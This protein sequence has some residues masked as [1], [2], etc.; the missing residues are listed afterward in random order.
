MDPPTSKTIQYPHGLITLI[1]LHQK[2]S[3]PH[4]FRPD[5]YN[6]KAAIF[7]CTWFI[8]L[9]SFGLA[10]CPSS[11]SIL[12]ILLQYFRTVFQKLSVKGGGP[13]CKNYSRDTP[14]SSV[15]HRISLWKLRHAET[16]WVWMLFQTLEIATNDIHIP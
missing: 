6:D 12:Q 2:K 11:D 15:L 5:Y 7:R 1:M 16:R 13:Y 8:S 4:P 14:T 9:F 10:H 3:Y